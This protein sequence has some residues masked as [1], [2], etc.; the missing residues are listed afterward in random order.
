[1]AIEVFVKTPLGERCAER[2]LSD[3][4]CA[5]HLIDIEFVQALRRLVTAGGLPPNIAQLALERLHDWPIER[6]EHVGLVSRIWQLRESV[7]A[8]DASYVALA[9]ILSSPLV[10]CDVKLSRSHGH[11][12]K[13]ELVR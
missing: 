2:V 11:R 7:S 8:Y 4:L 5:P 3:D 13:I 12:A 10:T 1:M 6:Y 9:E